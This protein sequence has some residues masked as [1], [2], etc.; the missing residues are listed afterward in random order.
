MK[1]GVFLY[2][3]VQ[4]GYSFQRKISRK[5]EIFQ[6][7]RQRSALLRTLVVDNFYARIMPWPVKVFLSIYYMNMSRIFRERR[8]DVYEIPHARRCLQRGRE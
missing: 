2:N 4:N 3:I 1:N 8:D 6:R 7:K 5:K